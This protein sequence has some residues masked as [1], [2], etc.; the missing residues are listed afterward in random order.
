MDVLREFGDTVN[1]YPA[2]LLSSILEVFA[3]NYIRIDTFL[4]MM[5]LF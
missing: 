3:G 4:K 2:I 5:I 1:L